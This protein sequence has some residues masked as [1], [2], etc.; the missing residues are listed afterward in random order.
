MMAVLG[1]ILLVAIAAWS[2]FGG[3][4]NS[5][6]PLPETPAAPQPKA[7]VGKPSAPPVDTKPAAADTG[8]AKKP[9][10]TVAQVVARA[11]TWEP[12]YI[13]YI[14]KP[15]PEIIARDL[16]GKP[17]KLSDYKGRNVL[18]VFWATWCPPCKEEI[19]GLIR[20]RRTV[21]ED[22]LAIIA[23]STDRMSDDPIANNTMYEQLVGLLKRFVISNKI[24]Y[25]VVTLPG[26]MDSPYAQVNSLP[27]TFFI[28]QEGR[29]KLATAG[30]MPLGDVEAI[31]AADK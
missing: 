26:H 9:T 11:K 13:R 7:D 27:S 21:P 19:P 29:I 28:D 17:V 22:K 23:V 1:A 31:L 20:L 3:T 12:A 30:A 25:T 6:Q 8:P 18:V 15:S 2:F 16:G 5:P 24:N 10:L 4:G 14:G